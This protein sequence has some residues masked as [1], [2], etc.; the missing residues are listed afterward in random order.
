MKGVKFKIFM[1]LAAAAVLCLM[2]TAVFAAMGLTP[3]LRRAL[4]TVLTPFRY[5]ATAVSGAVEGYVSYFTDYQ[6]LNEENAVLKEQLAA[7]QEQVRYAEMLENEN[8]WLRGYLGVKREHLDFEMDSALVIGRE[9]NN[10]SSVLTLNRGS[11][12]GIS[13][14]MVVITEDGIVGSIAEVGATWSKVS[15][16][17]QTRSAVGAYIERSNA[18]GVVE[19]TFA[20]RGEG[21][22]QLKYLDEE[23]DVQVG[24]RVLSS[25]LG[26]TFPRGLVIGEVIALTPDPYERT[27]IATVKPAVDF[28]SLSQVMVLTSFSY[29]SHTVEEE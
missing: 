24:D 9:E 8:R 29:S 16:L 17:F 5:A 3:L 22:C 6:A 14:G 1:G 12:N 20:L 18:V 27:I 21:L 19:G 2:V 7:Y 25:G 10:Y 11:A 4:G 13:E 26:S 15:P 23:A 28:E